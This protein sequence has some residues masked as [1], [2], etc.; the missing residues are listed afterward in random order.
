LSWRPN[1]IPALTPRPAFYRVENRSVGGEPDRKPEQ[2]AGLF[3]GA[4]QVLDDAPI[5]TTR[6]AG[7]VPMFDS[8]ATSFARMFE[9]TTAKKVKASA[10]ARKAALAWC[11]IVLAVS[12]ASVGAVCHSCCGKVS[13]WFS[14]A[15]WRRTARVTKFIFPTTCEPGIAARPLRST[16][17]HSAGRHPAVR[18]NPT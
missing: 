12:G 18:A 9:S 10:A 13:G 3:A 8:M 17:S 5:G 16:E 14:A 1:R 4:S 6:I 11:R 7:G 2:K 15:T